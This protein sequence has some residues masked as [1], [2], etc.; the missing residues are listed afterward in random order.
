[1]KNILCFGDS[2][3]W[4][5]DAESGGRYAYNVR[6]TSLLQEALGNEYN[7]IVDGLNGRTTVFE[8]PFSPFRNGSEA[9]PYALLSHSPLDLVVIML[10]TNDSKSFFRNTSFAIGR[11]ARRLIEF[12]QDSDSGI[13]GRSP[14]ILLI[15]PA[16]VVAVESDKAAFD[17]R[18]FKNLDGHDPVLVSEMLAAEYKNIAEV[19]GC[20][21][22]D[23]SEVAEVSQVDGVHL[24]AK[25]HQGLAAAAAEQILRRGI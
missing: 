21:F 19:Y 11:G 17:L 5:Y 24:T 14:E 18:E 3:T 10:G 12:T 25:G 13:D 1:M 16:P 2:N 15:S 20:G 23:A 9:L 7:I 6:W 8:D 4:G 22:L